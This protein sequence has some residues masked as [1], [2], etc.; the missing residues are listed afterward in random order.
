VGDLL[1]FRRASA[2]RDDP[3]LETSL[4][5]DVTADDNVDLK[6]DR[7]DWKLDVCVSALFYGLRQFGAQLLDGL[8]KANPVHDA[9]WDVRE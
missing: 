3:E 9:S 7:P 4:G 8:D 5:L 2:E 6:L 1:T